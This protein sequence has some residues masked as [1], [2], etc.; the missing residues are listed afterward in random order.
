MKRVGIFGGTFNPVHNTHL[1]MAL[2]FTKQMELDLC[3]FV[4]AFKSPFKIEENNQDNVQHRI[5][6]LELAIAGYPKF[7]VE[8]YEAERKMVSYS[9]DTIKYLKGKYPNA[10]LYFL[11]GSDQIKDFTKWKNWEDILSI[12][13]LCIVKRADFYYDIDFLMEKGQVVF[14]DFLESDVS[15]SKIREFIRKAL[16]LKGLLPE[17]VE[18]YI[19]ENGLYLDD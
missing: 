13:R 6:M 11:I 14:I 7:A 10:E 19:K 5:K 3:L 16:P 9:I 18:L 17:T 2:E 15:S 8:K 1:K 4:P 12:V